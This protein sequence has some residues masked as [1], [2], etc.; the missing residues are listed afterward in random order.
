MGQPSGAIFSIIT[1][2][3]G[4]QPISKSLSEVSVSVKESMTAETPVFKSASVFGLKLIK[5]QC[6]STK[7][8]KDLTT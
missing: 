4:R 5:V 8:V 2:S 1:V 6:E 3:P 7:A